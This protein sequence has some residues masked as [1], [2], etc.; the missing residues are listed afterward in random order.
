MLIDIA[1]LVVPCVA[2]AALGWVSQVVIFKRSEGVKKDEQIDRLEIHRDE[3]T[4]ELLENARA[5]M[6]ILRTELEAMRKETNTLRKLER[7][8]YHFQQ[9]LDH[10]EALLAATTEDERALA[11]RNARAFLN[12]MRRLAD[13]EGNIAN[14][15]QR[16]QS[17]VSIR[18]QGFV[19]LKGSDNVDKL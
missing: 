14:E 8:I 7:H 1:K 13:A 15:V 9:S 10:L 12:R 16:V 5:E 4:F 3:L 17:E 6:T 18:D 11:E 2:S 19:V